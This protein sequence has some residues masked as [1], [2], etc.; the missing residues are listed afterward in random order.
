MPGRIILIR[1]GV[2]AKF[3]AKAVPLFDLPDTSNS[4]VAEGGTLSIFDIDGTSADEYA[5]PASRWQALGSPAGSSGYKYRGAGTLTDPCRI[6]LVKAR[7]VKAVCKGEGVQIPTPV[8]GDVGVVLDIGTDTKTYCARF[9]GAEI[10][11]DATLL[12]RKAAPTPVVCPAPPGH[13]QGS[14]TSTST[15]TTSSSTFGHPQG[16]VTSTSTSTTSSSTL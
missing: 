14:V 7:V 2:V 16:S 13:P 15:S 10:R 11:N 1:T 6:V 8:N 4:P 9:G 5:L 12:K 3:I